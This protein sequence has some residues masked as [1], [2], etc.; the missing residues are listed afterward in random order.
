[1]R[2]LHKEDWKAYVTPSV[3]PCVDLH[4]FYILQHKV[5]ECCTPHTKFGIRVDFY[6]L[7]KS[8]FLQIIKL[9]SWRLCGGSWTAVVQIL[10]STTHFL[11][12]FSRACQ[13]FWKAEIT[14]QKASMA[15][16]SWEKDTRHQIIIRIWW[17]NGVEFPTLVFCCTSI[18]FFLII[19]CC[20]FVVFFC[21]YFFSLSFLISYNTN[22]FLYL[23][24]FL[25]VVVCFR[26][27]VVLVLFFIIFTHSV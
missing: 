22:P 13:R 8:K 10:V 17:G 7:I 9:L 21:F 5:E 23:F 2:F 20:A 16:L 12:K 11:E 4:K 19:F 15:A 3:T 6:T 14:K 27:L 25:V 26:C 1:M 24:L 18:H